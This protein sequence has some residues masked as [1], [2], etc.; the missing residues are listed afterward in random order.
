[1]A[2]RASL[3]LASGVP[4]GHDWRSDPDQPPDFKIPG[5]GCHHEAWK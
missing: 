2:A 1:V 3:H 4:A 5:I